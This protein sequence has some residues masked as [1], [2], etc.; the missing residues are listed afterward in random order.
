MSL[1][2]KIQHSQDEIR[3]V[4]DYCPDTGVFTRKVKVRYGLLPGSVAGSILTDRNGRRYIHISFR[5]KK[6]LA[7]RL[8][9]VWMGV[10]LPPTVD[11]IDGNGENNA[12]NNLREATAAQNAWNSSGKKINKTGLKGVKSHENGRGYRGYLYANG[13]EHYL[14]Y[15]KSPEEAHAAYRV[16]AE[17]YHG[18]YAWQGHERSA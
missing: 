8:A 10:P 12:W 17:K 2:V 16:A 7:H 15:F 9:F 18:D 13:K 1:G 3:R 11:H 5:G 14:G 4:L 6:Y